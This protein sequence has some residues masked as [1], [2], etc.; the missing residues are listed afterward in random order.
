MGIEGDREIEVGQPELHWSQRATLVPAPSR[1]YET[2]TAKQRRPPT[3]S[4]LRRTPIIWV[5]VAC[6][7]VAAGVAAFLL[8]NA[9]N[10]AAAEQKAKAAALAQMGTYTDYA[11]GVSFQVPIAWEQIPLEDATSALDGLGGVST[12]PSTY[13]AFGQGSGLTGGAGSGAVMVFAAQ[14]YPGGCGQHVRQRD[15]RAKPGH[16][17]GVRPSWPI[18]RGRGQGDQRSGA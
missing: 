6:L 2:P 16:L 3:G 9:K 4:R 17:E 10:A 5:V 13:V 15:A 1:A 12:M 14:D 18:I 11:T 8:I 7:V